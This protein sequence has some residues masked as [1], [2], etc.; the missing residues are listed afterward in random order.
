VITEIKQRGK[1]KVEAEE[2][3]VELTIITSPKE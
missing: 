3:S 2:L 1:E